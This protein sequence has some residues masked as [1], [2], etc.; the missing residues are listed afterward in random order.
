MPFIEA[1][2]WTL[3]LLDEK[4]TLSGDDCESWAMHGR[5]GIWHVNLHLCHLHRLVGITRPSE[6][7]VYIPVVSV[8]VNYTEQDVLG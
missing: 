7:A 1:T 2:D 8:V 5:N 3:K 6:V 4:T